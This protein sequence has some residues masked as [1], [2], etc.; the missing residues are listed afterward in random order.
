MVCKQGNDSQKAVKWLQEEF[1]TYLQSALEKE[2][3]VKSNADT[4]KDNSQ[5]TTVPQ[6]K[7]RAVCFRDIK[8]GLSAWTKQIDSNFPE[9]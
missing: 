3:P 7:R 1:D 5:E 2:S 6:V 9:Y 4:K 8:G